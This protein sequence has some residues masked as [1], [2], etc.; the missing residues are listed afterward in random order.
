MPNDFA[1]SD[2][3]NDTRGGDARGVSGGSGGGTDFAT[4]LAQFEARLDTRFAKTSR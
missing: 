3:D 2:A 1:L 4:L